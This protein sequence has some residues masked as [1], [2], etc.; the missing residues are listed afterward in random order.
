MLRTMICC[1]V[2]VCLGSVPSEA[3]VL[4]QIDTFQG[5]TLQGW[6]GGSSPA[7]VATW[8]R[9]PLALR[10]SVFGLGGTFTTTDEVVLETGLGW[11]S[12]EFSLAASEST[13]TAGF[14]TLG[15]TLA[16]VSTLLIRHDPDPL[17]PSGQ[18]NHVTGT[19]GIDNVTALPEPGGLPTL[20]AGAAALAWLSGR[21]RRR[22]R[23]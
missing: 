1:G 21:R 11:V 7:N 18:S 10:I 12:V 3:I 13:Q 14:G 9:A 22:G 4:G 5:G 20:A 15:D 23:R 17:S 6:Q 19:L 2:L 8:G 16:S